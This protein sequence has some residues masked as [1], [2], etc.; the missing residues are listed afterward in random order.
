MS[1]QNS[2]IA[3]IL[4]FV[5]L[6]EEHDRLLEQFPS[7]NSIP[8]SKF[9]YVEHDIK[10]DGFRMISVL[11]EGM[12]IDNAFDATAAGIS[13]FKP[14]LIVCLGIAGSLTSDL[15]IG[16]VSVSS[17]VIDVSQ[18]IKITEVV[19]RRKRRPS[20]RAPP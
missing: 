4:V 1:G 10:T 14:N 18:N 19:S 3:T 13:K 20:N 7:L 6:P 15:K 16:D 11:A 12:G 2:S 5:A 8:D 9:V 17:E